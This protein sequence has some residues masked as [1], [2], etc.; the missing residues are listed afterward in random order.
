[1]FFFFDCGAKTISQL[2]THTHAYAHWCADFCRCFWFYKRRVKQSSIKLWWRWWRATSLSRLP[3][4][5]EHVAG[6]KVNCICILR[7]T[8]WRSRGT[9]LS[10]RCENLQWLVEITFLVVW[11]PSVWNPFWHFH[12]LQGKTQQNVNRLLRILTRMHC[13]FITCS[14][15]DVA[16]IYISHTVGQRKILFTTTRARNAKRWKPRGFT[17]ATGTPTGSPLSSTA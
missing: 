9:Q 2:H 4:Q 13:R 1:M 10:C 7:V 5:V 16:A 15:I 6:F 12:W 17:C 3:E 14:K 8:P 11:L